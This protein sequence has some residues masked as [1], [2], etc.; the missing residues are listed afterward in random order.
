MALAICKAFD[1]SRVE[2]APCPLIGFT[3]LVLNDWND[4]SNGFNHFPRHNLPRHSASRRWVVRWNVQHDQHPVVVQETSF[5][6]SVFI[7]STEIENAINGTKKSFI[8]F[9][10]YLL[11]REELALETG[12]KSQANA[13]DF[14]AAGYRMWGDALPQHLQGAFL[15]VIWDEESDKL[16]VARDPMGLH[17]CYYFW[18]GNIFL[19]SA[20]IHL[21]LAQDDISSQINRVVLAEYIENRYVDQQR[22]ETFYAS[23]RRLPP[24]H[25]LTVRCSGLS[26]ERYWD[27]F[28]PG[29][30]WASSEELTEFPQRLERSVSRCLAIGADSIALSGGFDSVSIAVAAAKFRNDNVPLYAISLRFK[31]TVCDEGETQV[32]VASALGM[33]Q[34]IQSVSESL[35]HTDIVQ[36]SLAFSAHSPLPVLSVW[37]SLY[38]GLMQSAHDVGCRHLLMGTGGDDLL[39]VDFAYALD[40]LA[41]GR[42]RQLWNFYHVCR[43]TSPFSAWAMARGVLWHS[44]ARPLLGQLV[45]NLMGTVSPRTLKRLREHRSCQIRSW[46]AQGDRNFVARLLERR[47]HYSR[48]LIAGEGAYE[49]KM[50]GLPQAPLLL[51]EHDQ[52]FAWANHFGFTLLQP[53]W[54]KEMVELTLRIHPEQLIEGGLFKTPLREYVR[55][56]LPS[57][58]LPSKKVDF[59]QS[60][61]GILRAYLRLQGQ[62]FTQFPALSDLGIIEVDQARRLLE[63]YRG[64]SD[65]RWVLVWNLLSAEAWL[66]A[67]STGV[68]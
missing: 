3:I 43:R 25:M 41:S 8:A 48:E 61:H 24:A 58:L 52:A 22:E 7:S 10:G 62:I 39:N 46:I 28:P 49:R 53:F 42:W 44:S 27:P 37:Q 32:R 5:N 34:M 63:A 54:D 67:Q 36:A 60:V 66:Q 47:R 15:L 11:A 12:I 65:D 14:I 50:R 23:I 19:V 17:P 9:D 51:M 4:M 68:L 1:L 30:K 2:N 64:G 18:D 40:C 13:I 20:S 6:G 31:E 35:E 16:I 56:N 21:L 26:N 33:P 29:F 55:K 45:A 38:S 57:V 59:T